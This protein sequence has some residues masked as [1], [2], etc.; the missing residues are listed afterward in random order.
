MFFYL[1]RAAKYNLMMT[2]QWNGEKVNPSFNLHCAGYSPGA[3]LPSYQRR[4]PPF[5]PN[6]EVSVRVLWPDLA[7][8]TEKGHEANGGK[9]TGH[10]RGRH[11]SVKRN[12][13][14]LWCGEL[15][16]CRGSWK[17]LGGFPVARTDYHDEQSRKA[18]SWAALK[19]EGR[20]VVVA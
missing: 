5:P 9:H 4:V 14:R 16:G 18:S 19:R 10:R 8:V 17:E 15:P 20:V 2:V 3:S 13:S 6:R 11:E 7:A 1:D 12:G